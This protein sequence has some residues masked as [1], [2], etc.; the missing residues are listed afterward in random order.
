MSGSVR[1]A[2][3]LMAGSGSRLSDGENKRLKPLLPVD[4]RPLISYTLDAMT[5]AGIEKIYAVIG[6]Q[7]ETLRAGVEPLVPRKIDIRWIDNPHWQLQNGISLL[8]A[9]PHVSAPF[10]LT[11]GDHLF[12]AAIVDLLL[13]ESK[14]DRLNVAIDRKLESIFDLDDAMKLQVEGEC[15]TAIGKDLENY[16]A[17]DTGLFVGPIE[18]FSYLKKAKANGDCSLADGVRAMAADELVRAVDIGAAWWQDVDT[19]E[20]LANAEKQLHAR[21]AQLASAGSDRRDTT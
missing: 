13:R 11:M 16:S 12:D 10:L 21:R 19:R 15:V 14:L 17:I 7:G 5:R 8:A 4:G 2:V 9:A 1:E 20:M 18:F 6:F 3:I